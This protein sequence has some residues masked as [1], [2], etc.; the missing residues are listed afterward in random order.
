MPEIILELAFWIGPTPGTAP[1]RAN[2]DTY[3]DSDDTVNP[4]LWV[5]F[6]L[7]IPRDRNTFRDLTQTQ[8]NFYPGVRAMGVYHSQSLHYMG[9]NADPRAEYEFSSNYAEGGYNTGN[10]ENYNDRAQTLRC[11]DNSRWYIGRDST[12][13]ITTAQRSNANLPVQYVNALNSFVS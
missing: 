13:A 10:M 6:H 4:D 1:T 2:L 3:G 12:T 9:N 8:R 11:R 5:I 7:H